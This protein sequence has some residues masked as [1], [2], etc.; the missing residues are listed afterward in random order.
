V[1]LALLLN[2]PCTITRRSGAITTDTYGN[3]IHALE[4]VQSTCELQQASRSESTERGDVSH[5][6]WRLFLPAGTHVG[7][8]DTV[9]VDGEDFEIVGDPWP[10]RNPRT[11]TVSHLEATVTR[12]A[13][14]GDPGSAS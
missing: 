12:R 4:S 8:A 13:A 1:S 14:P 2:R 3:E 7:A 9:T 6:D 10:A 11:Q 5:R